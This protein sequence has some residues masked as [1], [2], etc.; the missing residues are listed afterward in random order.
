ML[1]RPIVAVIFEHGEFTAAD[2]VA[3]AAALQFYAIGLVGYSVVRIISPTFYA[4]GRSRVPVMVSALSVLVN[5]ALNVTLVRFIGYRG[6][7]ARHVDHGDHQC[8]R[9]TVAAAP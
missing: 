1:A 3:T 9:A 5:V 6:P 4:L 2:T 8:L 7:G